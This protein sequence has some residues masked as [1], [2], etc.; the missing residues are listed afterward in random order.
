MTET[1]TADVDEAPVADE[2]APASDEQATGERARGEETLAIPLADLRPALEAVLMGADQPRDEYSVATAADCPVTEACAPLAVLAG[3][4]DAGGG[5]FEL[6]NVA[7][8]WR[9]C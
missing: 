2:A 6:R 1:H 9:Y 3:E 7:G 5:G 8:G 4:Y